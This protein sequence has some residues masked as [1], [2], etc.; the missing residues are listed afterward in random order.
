MS[1][2][3]QDKQA[4]QAFIAKRRVARRLAVIGA[5]QWVITKNSFTELYV[6]FQ[7]DKELAE[8]FRKSDAAFCHKLMRAAI[9]EGDVITSQLE[10]FLSRKLF[11][12]DAIEHAVLRVATAE[13]LNHPETPYKVVVNEA[14]NL[15]KKYGGEQAHKFINGVLD[16]VAAAIR[17]D[18]VKAVKN[19]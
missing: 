7:D 15:T 14:V 18:E 5:Y 10:P 4:Q 12:V 11:Q 16:K 6:N 2:P 3:D 8:D 13:L 17:A 19:S 1:V 9:E